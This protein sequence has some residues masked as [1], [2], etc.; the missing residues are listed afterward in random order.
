MR[1]CSSVWGGGPG[2]GK[3]YTYARTPAA[4]N[5]V[6]H[7]IHTGSTGSTSQPRGSLDISLRLSD[8]NDLPSAT[9]ASGEA[10]TRDQ[11]QPLS[12][13]PVTVVSP[14]E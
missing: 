11:C 10:V 1:N 6:T 7:N 12:S 9:G 14:Q 3:Q 2:T 4:C 8:S 5:T 13:I